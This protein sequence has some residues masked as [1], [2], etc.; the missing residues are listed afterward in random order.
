MTVIERACVFV[1]IPLLKK[2]SG[3]LIPTTI[4]AALH[5]LRLIGMATA[6]QLK[7]RSEGK[8]VGRSADF[9]PGTYWAVEEL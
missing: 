8:Q 7:G 1:Q 4:L 9:F 6:D 2:R 3:M 5:L